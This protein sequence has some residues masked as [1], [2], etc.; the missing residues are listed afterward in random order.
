MVWVGVVNVTVSVVGP[1]ECFITGV[2]A[3]RTTM[4]YALVYVNYLKNKTC[5][6][7]KNYC[8]RVRFNTLL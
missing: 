8:W 4:Y 3:E 2:T 5:A 6:I 7:N 1:S